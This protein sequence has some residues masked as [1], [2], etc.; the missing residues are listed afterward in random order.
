MNTVDKKFEEWALGFSGTDGGDMGSPQEPAIW[1][2]GIEWGGG[3]TA[4]TLQKE[5]ATD[6]SS[7]RQGYS[8]WYYNIKFRFNAQKMKLLSAVLGGKVSDY[9]NFAE[10]AKPFCEGQK[11]FFKTNIYPVGFRNVSHTHWR[12]S[13]AEVTGFETKRSYMDWC[14]QHRFPVMRSWVAKAKPRLI[15]C[16]GVNTA[17]DF[18][19]AYAESD[20]DFYLEDIEGQPLRWLKNAED[21][22]VVV[23]P[24][25]T[26]PTGLKRNVAIQAF[27]DR[28]CELMVD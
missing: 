18:K 21:T 7:P 25:M 28:I 14:R 22:L 2:S 5:L 23:V 10:T 27:G 12:H 13:I 6:V 19:C 17:D 24:F 15:I 11:G 8:D 20:K 26:S 3:H 1:V 9:K 4:E 16:A